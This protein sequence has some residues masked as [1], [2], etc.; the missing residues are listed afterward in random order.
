CHKWEEFVW[1]WVWNWELH[2]IALMEISLAPEVEARLAGIASEAGKAADQ[3]VQELVADYLDHDEWFKGGV[4]KGL[5]SLG[6]GKFVSHEE[7]GRQIER[8]LRP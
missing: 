5:A 7:V 4:Q 8:I 2:T 1:R 6:D 3:I